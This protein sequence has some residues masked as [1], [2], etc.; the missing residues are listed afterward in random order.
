MAT[1]LKTT[2]FRVVKIGAKRY[3]LGLHPHERETLISIRPHGRRVPYVVPVSTVRVHAALAYGRAEQAAKREA[4]KASIKWK[5][6][7]KK[8]LANL[9]PPQVKSKRGNKAEAEDLKRAGLV[10]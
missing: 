9:L 7:R 3:V 4:R 1:E 5:Y 6:A 10:D 8:F 2:V